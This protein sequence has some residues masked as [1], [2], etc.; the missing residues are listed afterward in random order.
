MQLLERLSDAFQRNNPST[1]AKNW[2]LDT[3]EQTFRHEMA[4]F[5]QQPF[6]KKQLTGRRHQQLM[7][8]AVTD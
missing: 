3:D 1:R 4:I 8:I 5:G 2:I 7:Q 6:G